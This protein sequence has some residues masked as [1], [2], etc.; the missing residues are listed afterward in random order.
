MINSKKNYIELI[1][2]MVYILHSATKYSYTAAVHVDR[3]KK[4]H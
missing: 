3:K 2:D 1:K 4:K